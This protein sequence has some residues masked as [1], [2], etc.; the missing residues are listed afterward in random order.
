M[1]NKV[2]ETY[3]RDAT[4]DGNSLP[5]TICGIPYIMLIGEKA[6]RSRRRHE[7]FAPSNH[8]WRRDERSGNTGKR[9]DERDSSIVSRYKIQRLYL[10]DN[11]LYEED[12]LDVTVISFLPDVNPVFDTESGCDQYTQEIRESLIEEIDM[13]SAALP[14][15]TK[16][17]LFYGAYRANP[18]LSCHHDEHESSHERG[19]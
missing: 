9:H 16:S 3:T 2:L 12:V 15:T 18:F 19:L 7:T 6:T 10:R 4:T 11:R 14:R 13:K 8:E 5:M 1:G 17:N